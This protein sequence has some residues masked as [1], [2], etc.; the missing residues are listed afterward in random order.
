MIG[1]QSAFEEWAKARGFVMDQ[2]PLHYIFLDDRTNAA[3]DGWRAGV[4]YGMRQVP[5]PVNHIDPRHFNI[6]A[7]ALSEIKAT[8]DGLSDQPI[9]DIV[10]GCLSEIE[11]LKIV[12]C[13]G[14]GQTDP[15]K[16]CVGCV[17]D[18][19]DASSAWVRSAD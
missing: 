10:A 11:A 16:R 12:S 9:A 13:G 7:E 1:E 8:S 18:F 19:G 17:H 5:E 3:R 2:H 6:L 14:C 15:I 4:S